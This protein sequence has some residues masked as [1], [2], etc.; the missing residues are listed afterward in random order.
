MA[1]FKINESRH[2]CSDNL[3]HSMCEITKPSFLPSCW[4]QLL[5]PW[6]V[7]SFCRS[8]SAAEGSPMDWSCCAVTFCKTNELSHLSA[9]LHSIIG[10]AK[11]HLTSIRL[12]V[13]P[14]V[15][16]ASLTVTQP[17]VL[18]VLRWQHLQRLLSP[19]CRNRPASSP[20]DCFEAHHMLS[21][22]GHPVIAHDLQMFCWLC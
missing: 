13:S 19:F 6:S 18:S 9:T 4:S 17:S 15:S 10:T 2:Y 14:V 16:A 22:T 1:R 21:R 7:R 5:K 20:V 3:L 12:D 11:Q 8:S